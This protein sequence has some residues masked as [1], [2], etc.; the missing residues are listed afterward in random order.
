MSYNRGDYR[1][2]WRIE[3]RAAGVRSDLGLDQ[4]QVLDPG[5]LAGTLGAE[6]LHLSD[7]TD[8]EIALR[9]ARSISFDGMASTH[10]AD[11]TPI[12]V[13]NC[14]KPARRR[15]ATLMEELGH[16]VLGHRPSRIYT[17]TELGVLRRSYD[18][19]QE[20]EAYDLGA[21][22]LLPKERIQRDVGQRVLIEEIA[23]AH[24]CSRELVT[25]RINRMRLAR[26]YASY[27]RKAS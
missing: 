15:I 20:Q 8:D 11:G 23:D 19:A 10:P 5:A 3:K 16:L 27:G 18:K 9:R 24:T 1:D 21:A 4:I 6:I 26:R 12:I 13:L 25:Y 14:G 7:L 22:L 2:K 17:D